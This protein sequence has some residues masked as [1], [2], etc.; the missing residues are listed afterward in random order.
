V[1]RLAVLATLAVA[2]LLGRPAAA[3]EPVPRILQ[4]VGVDERVDTTPDLDLTVTDQDGNQ[5]K[6]ADLL[7]G[8]RPVL[9][10]LNYY[11]CRMICSIQLQALAKALG[12]LTWANDERVR[13]ATVSIDPHETATDAKNR[14]TACFAQ[15]GRKDLDWTFCVADDQTVHALAD[16]VGIHYTYDAKSDQYAHPAT[17]VFLSPEGKITRYLHGVDVPGQDLKLGVLEASRGEVGTPFDR[18]VLSCYSYDAAAGSYVPV[19][20]KIMRL[21]GVVTLLLLGAFLGALWLRERRRTHRL[22]ALTESA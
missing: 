3:A 18:L 1:R 16:R 17:I 5:L 21:G 10:T 7:D 15:A 6:L 20:W 22:T 11:R 9:L 4:D 14:R 12:Q 2:G 19:A 13:V 8:E